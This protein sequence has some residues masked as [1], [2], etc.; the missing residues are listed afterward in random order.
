MPA[1]SGEYQ[2]AF[3][4][5]VGH[6]GAD[7]G[8]YGERIGGWSQWRDLFESTGVDFDNSNETIEAF[9]S[10]L[11]AYYPQE[12]L[13]KTDWEIIRIEY[14]EMYGTGDMDDQFWAAWREAIGY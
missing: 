6:A 2:D 8:F 14:A 13:D 11:V 3:R 10:F 7:E 1:S 5:M 12:G 9:E 4:E